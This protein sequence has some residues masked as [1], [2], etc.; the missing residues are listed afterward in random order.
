MDIQDC[1]AQKQQID[2]LEDLTVARHISIMRREHGIDLG[3]NP[4]TMIISFDAC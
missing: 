4:W 1:E 2:N 3:H